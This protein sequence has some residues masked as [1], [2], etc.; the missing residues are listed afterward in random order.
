LKEIKE[1]QS[2]QAEPKREAVK[3]QGKS[4]KPPAQ[5][6]KP[7]AKNEFKKPKER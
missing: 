6:N 2:E 7:K 3:E 4:T 5:L 1:A